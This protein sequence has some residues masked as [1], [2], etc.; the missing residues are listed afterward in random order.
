MKKEIL[1]KRTDE[2]ISAVLDNC[3]KMSEVKD[4]GLLRK[5]LIKIIRKTFNEG[6]VDQ[7]RDNRPGWAYKGKGVRNV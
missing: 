1:K 2:I 6:R 3:A 5:A 7:L 4:S